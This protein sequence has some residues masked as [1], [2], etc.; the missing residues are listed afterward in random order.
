MSLRVRLT[1]L[2]I[3]G[4][5]VGLIHA[6]CPIDKPN[7]WCGTTAGSSATKDCRLIGVFGASTATT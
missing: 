1:M 2:A 3:L 4:A 7:L 5:L 6:G